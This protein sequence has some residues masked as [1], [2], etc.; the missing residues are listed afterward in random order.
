MKHRS[1]NP[2]VVSEPTLHNCLE[3]RRQSYDSLRLL[4]DIKYSICRLQIRCDFNSTKNSSS[5]KMQIGKKSGTQQKHRSIPKN[6]W[7]LMKFIVFMF[8][9]SLNYQTFYHKKHF[10]KPAP[11]LPWCGEKTNW[12]PWKMRIWIPWIVPPCCPIVPC[13]S[14]LLQRWEHTSTDILWYAAMIDES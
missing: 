12:R 3:F 6:H 13:A 1:S 7:N 4:Y 9:T 2:F 8:P 14:A 10:S 5:H 11:T